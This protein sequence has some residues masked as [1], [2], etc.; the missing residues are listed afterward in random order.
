MVYFPSLKGTL[1]THISLYKIVG[2]LTGGIL[3]E[4]PPN[5]KNF[6]I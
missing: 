2:F 3:D 5:P 1:F 6:V 4:A